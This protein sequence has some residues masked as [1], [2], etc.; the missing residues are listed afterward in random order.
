MVTARQKSL[1]KL[2]NNTTYTWSDSEGQLSHKYT[3]K[4]IY[5]QETQ[6]PT[7]T[8]VAPSAGAYKLTMY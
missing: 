3:Q 4:V 2:L 1:G 6:H 7:D 8:V 5:D